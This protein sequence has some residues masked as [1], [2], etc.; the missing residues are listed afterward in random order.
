VKDTEE[1]KDTI[2]VK[3]TEGVGQLMNRQN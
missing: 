3:D 2:E 1:V